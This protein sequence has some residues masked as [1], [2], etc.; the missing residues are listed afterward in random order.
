MFSSCVRCSVP[1]SA[2]MVYTYADRQVWLE[3]LDGRPTAGYAMCGTHADRLTPP[4]GW[5]LTDRRT[6]VR[7]FAPLEVA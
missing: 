3:D 6:V 5:T 1:A 4:L 7:L 2:R